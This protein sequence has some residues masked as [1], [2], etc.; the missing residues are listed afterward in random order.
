MSEPLCIGVIKVLPQGIYKWQ[1]NQRGVAHAML[2]SLV[3]IGQ[4]DKLQF[5]LSGV[6]TW[7]FSP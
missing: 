5:D 2:E 3:L 6:A 7:F 1:S 4:F